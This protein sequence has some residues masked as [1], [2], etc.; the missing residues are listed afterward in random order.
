MLKEKEIA[1]YRVEYK[2][3]NINTHKIE[4]DI[5]DMVIINQLIN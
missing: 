4:Y 3:S 5:T 2:I 1:K